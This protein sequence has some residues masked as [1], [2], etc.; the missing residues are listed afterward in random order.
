MRCAVK[1]GFDKMLGMGFL[2][3]S[4]FASL[5]SAQIPAPTIQNSGSRRFIEH[6]GKEKTLQ[7]QRLAARTETQRFLKQINH[8]LATSVG[9]S[10]WAFDVGSN[11]PASAW[12]AVYTAGTTPS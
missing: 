10:D 9:D 5:S 2:V 6:T 3:T 7:G 1:F 11:G 4:L 8:P 12:P